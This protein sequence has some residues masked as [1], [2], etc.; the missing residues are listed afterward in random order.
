MSRAR[1][2]QAGELGLA[3]AMLVLGWVSG[4]ACAEFYKN[5]Q[6]NGISASHQESGKLVWACKSGLPLELCLY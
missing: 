3:K 6:A 1:K 2:H 5:L 4:V